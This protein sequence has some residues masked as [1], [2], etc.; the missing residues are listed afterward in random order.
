MPSAEGCVKDGRVSWQPELF[1]GLARRS[2]E[3]VKQEG[4][5]LLI[6][7]VIEKSAKSRAGELGCSVGHGLNDGLEI[8]L[9]SDGHPGAV[10]QLERARLF[11]ER[12]LGALPLGDVAGDLRN[13]A[14]FALAI[15]NGRDGQGN[16]N[17][18]AVFAASTV[19]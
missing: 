8:Q 3:G 1:K 7:D 6:Y 19:S 15:V 12:F 14:D 16:V 9:R 17:Q 13:A 5:S 4:L 2:R 11:A 10:Q 18:L